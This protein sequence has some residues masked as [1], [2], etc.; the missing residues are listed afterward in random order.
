MEKINVPIYNDGKIALP[1]YETELSAGF[2]IRVD[3][4]NIQ[5]ISQLKG[6]GDYVYDKEEKHLVLLP[7]G[8][9]LL[10]TNLYVA[11]PDGYELQIRPRS[12]LSLKH[13][14]TVINSPGTIDSDY[15]GELGIIVLNT[16]AFSSFVIKH[17]DRMAQGVLKEV[18]QVAWET[19]NSIEELGATNRGAGG[20]G[21]S[22]V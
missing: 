13:G 5:Q 21:H 2:D 12:G 17:G 11:I 3:L 7:G 14:I 8:R 20:F 10:P 1:R 18:K 15:R 6:N 4:S 16:D 19:V 22:G 9:V